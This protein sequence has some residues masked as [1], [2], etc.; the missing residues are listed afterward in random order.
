MCLR[1]VSDDRSPA[2]ATRIA[3]TVRGVMGLRAD[4]ELVAAGTLPDDGK[5]IDDRRAPP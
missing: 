3:E 5:V 1:C 4:V 2:L